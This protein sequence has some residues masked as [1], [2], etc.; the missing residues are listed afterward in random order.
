MPL[1]LA[2]LLS[3]TLV[4]ASAQQ[5]LR[6][7]KADLS[8]LVVVG[9]SLS[10]GVQ[11]IALAKSQ[12]VHGFASLIAS[13]AKVKNWTLPLI[14]EPG[15]PNKLIVYPG[16]SMQIGP[17][18]LLPPLLP[19]INILEQAT[20]LS[21]PGYRIDDAT[22]RR[23]VNA[24]W[25][26]LTGDPVSGWAFQVLCYPL[27]V[28]RE[29]RPNPTTNSNPTQL[30]RALALA[31]TTVIVWLGSNDALVPAL[32]GALPA[33]TPPAA[34]QQSFDRLMTGLDQTGANVV[35]A[36]IPDVT[37]IPYFVSMNQVAKE[38]GIDVAELLARVPLE[39]DPQ[40]QP[41]PQLHEGDFVRRSALP[42]IKG[43]LSDPSTNLP[44]FCDKPVYALPEIPG[45]PAGKYPCL[46]RAAHAAAVQ[47]TINAYNQIIAAEAA[48][49]NAPLV[50][51]HRLVNDIA[52]GG[53]DVGGQHLT[54]EFLGGLFSLDGI[55]PGNTGYAVIA[56][57]FIRVMN[58]ELSLKIPAVSVADVFKSDPLKQYTR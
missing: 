27:G 41:D 37:A 9:D 45:F 5:P 13:Q 33:L 17:S 57:E 38:N 54:T 22:T 20:N 44:V 8:R 55:H 4:P 21:V 3:L 36:N 24:T 14:Y 34:F 47:N 29:F 6:P 51:I 15:I 25:P 56:N 16:P 39:T 2:G 49:R 28:C 30:E 1:A 26:N 35:L 43:V 42:L 48:T 7:T 18:P 50:D 53:I 10:A 11:N 19:R 52:A 32:T 23:P 31:P 12:Q 40:F 46:L 58:E